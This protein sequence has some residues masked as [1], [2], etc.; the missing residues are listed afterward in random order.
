MVS[1]VKDLHPYVKNKPYRFMGYFVEIG[2]Y[3][4]AKPPFRV[5]TIQNETKSANG[6]SIS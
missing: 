1:I 3:F 5:K 4:P 6:S 2:R